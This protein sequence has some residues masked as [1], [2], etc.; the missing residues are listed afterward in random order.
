MPKKSMVY[1]LLSIETTKKAVTVFIAIIIAIVT[2]KPVLASDSDDGIAG[3]VPQLL[4]ATSDRNSKISDCTLG[5]AVADAVCLALDSDIAIICGGDLLKNLLP[6]EITWA[7]LRATFP[8]DRRLA[9]AVITS[10]ELLN[11]LERGLS[12]ITLNDEERI[13]AIASEYD[14]FPQISG[15]TV[16]YDATAPVGG[17]VLEI[18]IGE[19][20]LDVGNNTYNI[21]LAATKH[22]LEGGYGLPPVEEDIVVSEITLSIAFA[23]YMKNGMPDYRETTPRVIPIGIQGGTLSERF[24]FVMVIVIILIIILGNGQRFRRKFDHKI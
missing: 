19:H 18:K 7:S 4:T 11:I 21:K 13:D 16:I 15:F 17:R 5:N 6:G 24:P 14:G 3:R 8:E 23:A 1:R 12:R 2:I 9:T 22:M 20:V 10:N